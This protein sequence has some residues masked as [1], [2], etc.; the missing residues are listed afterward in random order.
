MRNVLELEGYGISVTD[1]I[2][3]ENAVSPSSNA[4]LGFSPC[5]LWCERTHL[6]F[7]VPS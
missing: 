2:R 6:T 7:F 3:G 5:P 1:A 4:I